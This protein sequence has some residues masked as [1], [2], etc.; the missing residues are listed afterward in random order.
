[1]N[2]LAAQ[3]AAMRACELAPHDTRSWANLGRVHAHAGEYALAARCFREVVAIDAASADGWHDLGLALSKLGLDADALGAL[4]RA[5]QLA[6]DQGH[7]RP[8]E[9][10][11]VLAGVSTTARSTNVLR[12]EYVP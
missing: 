3:R 4:K 6:R 11:A 9:L 2:G 7:V 5:L 1:M 8:G 12:L 10:V